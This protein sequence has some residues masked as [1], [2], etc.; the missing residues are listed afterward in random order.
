MW[1]K[2]YKAKRSF[3]TCGIELI[4]ALSS[5]NATKHD[6]DNNSKT[7]WQLLLDLEFNRRLDKIMLLGNL[8]DRIRFYFCKIIM[9][10]TTGLSNRRGFRSIKCW[11]VLLYSASSHRLHKMVLLEMV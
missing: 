6:R 8:S 11:Q 7:C 10:E 2:G 1:E 5:T 4:V 3:K 9:A